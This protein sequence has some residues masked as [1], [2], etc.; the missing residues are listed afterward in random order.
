MCLKVYAADLFSV[1]VNN[2][3]VDLFETHNVILYWLF[4]RVCSFLSRFL[5]YLC[6]EGTFAEGWNDHDLCSLPV[7][8][9]KS[10]E[11]VLRMWTD[12]FVKPQKELFQVSRHCSRLIHHS[13]QLSDGDLAIKHDGNLRAL[14]TEA[15]LNMVMSLDYQQ[16]FSSSN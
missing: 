16:L 9:V 6:V 14:T 3:C 8:K 7:G 1:F 2:Y 15:V 11:F 10:W 12:V 5:C 4:G 13:R